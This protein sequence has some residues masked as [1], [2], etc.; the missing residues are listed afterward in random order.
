MAAL[1]RETLRWNRRIR[2]VGFE[3]SEEILEHLVWEALR[4]LRLCPARGRLLDAGSGAGF[5]GLVLA[6][7]RPAL[8]VTSAE[9][10]EKKAHFQRQAARL[11]GL[12]NFEAHAVHLEPGGPHS[13]WLGSFA[14]ATAQALAAPEALLPLL[15]GYLGPGGRIL[16]PRGSAWES[17][18]PQALA[19]AQKAGLSLLDEERHS[20]PVHGAARVIAVFGRK[21]GG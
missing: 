4:L 20:L 16:L 9:A 15:A 17:E 10:R 8:A 14:A 1:A 19:A 21:G 6:A 11:L 13:E 7:A 2:L 12:E 5:P 18:R 3:T